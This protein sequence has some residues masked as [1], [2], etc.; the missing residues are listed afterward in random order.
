MKRLPDTELEVMKALWALGTARRGILW[1]R[2]PGTAWTGRNWTS[3]APFWTSWRRKRNDGL[4]SSS[5]H[6]LPGGRRGW[7]TPRIRHRTPSAAQTTFTSGPTAPL[8]A[9]TSTPSPSRLW[10]RMPSVWIWSRPCGD[11]GSFPTGRSGRRLYRK[12]N[13]NEKERAIIPEEDCTL[14]FV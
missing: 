7:T 1:P 8:P 3:C 14:F 2:W 11:S 5:G 4:S 10:C 9:T 12:Q 13:K 6:A